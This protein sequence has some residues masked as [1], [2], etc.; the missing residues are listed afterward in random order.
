[1][2]PPRCDLDYRE[3]IAHLLT[4]VDL[5]RNRVDGPPPKNDIHP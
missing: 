5:E 1:M 4:L 2:T 3:S